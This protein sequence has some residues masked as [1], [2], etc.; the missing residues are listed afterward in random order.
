MTTNDEAE[1]ADVLL[2]TNFRPGTGGGGAILQS[3]LP[4][5]REELGVAVEWA[6]FSDAPAELVR[7]DERHLAPSLTRGS[8]RGV[9]DFAR[10]W[11]GLDVR[12]LRAIVA[13]LVAERRSTYWVVGDAECVLLAEM[14]AQQGVRVHL[15]M[16]DDLAHGQFARSRRLKRFTRVADWRL[17]RTLRSVATVDV[18]CAGMKRYYQEKFKSDSIVVHRYVPTS[19]PVARSQSA[20]SHITV[21]HIGSIYSAAEFS[22]FCAALEAYAASN[23]TFA[24]VLLIG[25]ESATARS[26][27][28]DHES[29]VKILG[30]HDEQSAVSILEACDFLYAMYPFDE[31]LSVFRQTSS[32]TKVTTYLQAQR[33]VFAHTPDDSSL[34]EVVETYE[35][36]VVCPSIDFV[37]VQGHLGDLAKMVAAGIPTA[38][39]YERARS[40]LHGRANIEALAHC[41]TTGYLRNSFGAE[42][43][44]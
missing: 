5:L 3:L 12:P 30:H 16:H 18:V 24:R 1:V 22:A 25:Q 15:T 40:E 21:G 23:E 38:A 7:R 2:L 32:P 14:L 13:A 36:G 11:L 34:A 35:I 10:F 20:R 17:G 26:V 29:L 28:A 6:Y 43:S 42:T 39:S 9:V 19:L 44:A 4:V 31:R 33:P 37:A 27:K 41:L 8:W